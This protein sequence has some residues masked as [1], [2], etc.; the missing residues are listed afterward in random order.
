MMLTT[1]WSVSASWSSTAR[2]WRGGRARDDDAAAAG[3]GRPLLVESRPPV[4]DLPAAPRAT[5]RVLVASDV[6][7]ELPQPDAVDEEGGG[8]EALLALDLAH[9]YVADEA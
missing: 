7:P 3:V 5:Q 1:P 6:G 8:D 9:A 2:R 4:A